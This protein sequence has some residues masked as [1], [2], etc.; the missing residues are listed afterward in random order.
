MLIVER[1]IFPSP[2]T[3]PF[4]RE[5]RSIPGLESQS[6][7]LCKRGGVELWFHSSVM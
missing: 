6:I 2:M 3:L 1:Q 7:A 5:R 4:V